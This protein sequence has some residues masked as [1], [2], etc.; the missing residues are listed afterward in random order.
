MPLI[1]YVTSFNLVLGW[2]PVELVAC[3]L[4][5]GLLLIVIKPRTTRQTV[6]LVCALLALWLA[7]A[8]PISVLGDHYLFTAAVIQL[9]LLLLVVP[10][11]LLLALPVDALYRT[12]SGNRTLSTLEHVLSRPLVA[13]FVSMLIVCGRFLPP[14]YETASQNEILLFAVNLLFLAGAFIF[15]WPVFAPLK[16]GRISPIRGMIYLFLASQAVSILGILLAMTLKSSY[17]V[18]QQP[19]DVLGILS[20]LR[21]DLQLSATADLEIGGVTLFGVGG[22]AILCFIIP[23]FIRW[24]RGQEK[25]ALQD[26]EKQIAGS[27]GQA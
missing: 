5:A 16:L 12:I 25:E 4:L 11:C 13:W 20:Q 14:I 6:Y 21:S 17:T 3:L 9:L 27:G 1:A 22:M 23:E 26:I 7:L 10:V 24:Y 2:K 19:N 15:W 8:S 18:Y